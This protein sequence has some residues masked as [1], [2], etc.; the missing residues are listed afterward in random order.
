MEA[1]LLCVGDIHLGR[2]PTRLPEDLGAV[3]SAEL[4]PAAA[5]KQS[6]KRAL[7]LE[8][9]AV[10]LAGDVVESLDDRFAAYAVLETGVRQLVAEGIEVFGVSGNHDGEALPRLADRI[11]GFRLLGRGGRWDRA[12]I[13][14]EH[15]PRIQLYGW[16]FPGRTAKV[17]PLESFSFTPHPECVSIGLLHGDLDASSSPY[18]P[19]RRSALE[20]LPLD[21]WLLG[22]VHKPDRLEQMRRPIGYLGSLSPLDPGEPGAR[23]PWL[24][25]VRGPGSVVMEQLALAPLRYERMEISVE[26]FQADDREQAE[27]WLVSHIL[28]AFAARHEQIR[29]ELETTKLVLCR[30]VLQGRCRAHR[31]IAQSIQDETRAVLLARVQRHFEAARFVVEKIEDHA[32]PAIDL[33]ELAGQTDLPGL[34]ASK[35]VEI[36]DETE[37]G[38]RLIEATR[39]A[40][41]AE[42]RRSTW[43]GLGQ[44]EA[45]DVRGLLLKAGLSALE[46]LL[47][48]RAPE[49][50]VV[51]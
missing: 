14:R 3:R 13:E 2:R 31:L 12:L 33:D 36:R 15:K 26:S 50:V 47:A 25:R 38:V 19:V 44:I 37:R 10:L 42:N 18:A 16:S 17:S 24:A 11:D 21:A 30:I 1:K 34:L 41:E 20:Q 48:Q 35:L 27:E 23:G 45:I 40:L 29:P 46:E 51:S 32:E 28:A 6:V 7:E 49:R 43:A 9:D 5:W 22:H 4:S 8:V 39:S